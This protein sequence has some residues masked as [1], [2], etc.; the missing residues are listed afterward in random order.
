MSVKLSVKIQHIINHMLDYQRMNGIVEQ[1]MTNVQTLYDIITS[2]IE[3][4]I[5][6]G[7]KYEI[8]VKPCIILSHD[9]ESNITEVV[10][11]HVILDVDGLEIDPSYETLSLKNAIYFKDYREFMDFLSE[12]S[13][14]SLDESVGI[15]TILE[16]YITAVGLSDRMNNGE[17][18]I[19]DKQFYDNQLD[20]VIKKMKETFL[21]SPVHNDII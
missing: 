5:K 11:Q 10:S 8:K 1:C 9:G 17:F 20:Y 15:K 4:T 16:G 12:R 14:K 3:S 13:K 21:C 2:N 7:T 18:L 19:S 6:V